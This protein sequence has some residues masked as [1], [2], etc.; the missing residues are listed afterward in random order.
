MGTNLQSHPMTPITARQRE[1]VEKLLNTADRALIAAR[2][3]RNLDPATREAI[4]RAIDAASR[5]SAM[6]ADQPVRET[7]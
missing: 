5:A 4:H 7:V 1:G 6:L 3:A 2:Q